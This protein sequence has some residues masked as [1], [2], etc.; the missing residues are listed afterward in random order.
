MRSGMLV[1]CALLIMPSNPYAM[2]ISG[3]GDAVFLSGKINYGDDINFRE[4]LAG[5][6]AGSIKTVWLSSP[7]GFVT[8][9]RDLGR[10]IRF[11]GM[12]TVVDAARSRCDSACTLLFTS[13]VRRIY[14]N[15]AGIA[16]K[17]GGAK[18]GLGF[19][20]GSALSVS[21]YVIQNGRASADMIDGYYEFGVGGAA[22]LVNR[23]GYKSIY[24]ISLKTALESGVATGSSLK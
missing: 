8:P 15:S 6:P 7:G 13:G 5:K 18:F 1:V 24:H 3:K 16:E 23:A 19:H 10:L 22:P 11:N 12:T 20:E 21:G 17:E 2:E 4:F 9:A 14:L